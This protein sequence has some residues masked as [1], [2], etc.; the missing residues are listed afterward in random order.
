MRQKYDCQTDEVSLFTVFSVT[1]RISV[2]RLKGLG[3][4]G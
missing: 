2:L 1:F 3:L 4:S